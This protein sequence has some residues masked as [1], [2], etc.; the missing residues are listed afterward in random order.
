MTNHEVMTNDKSTNESH[1]VNRLFRHSVIRASFVI[2][3][4]DFV[5]CILIR[6]RR[7]T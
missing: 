6:G 7:S 2:R 3:H 4:S 1:S 5:I